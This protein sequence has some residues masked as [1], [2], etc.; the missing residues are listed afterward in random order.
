M[1]SLVL[2]LALF[3]TN[4]APSPA[5]QDP[6][7]KAA[8]AIADLAAGNFAA[9]E[10]KFNARMQSAWPAGQL[11]TRWTMIVAGVG[12]HKDCAP[13][14]RVERRPG[15]DAVTTT[16]RFE[17]AAL[18]IVV[19]IDS[20]GKITGLAFRPA[21]AATA[22]Y[23]PPSYAHP[24]AYTEEEL[25][26]G[27][28]AWLLPG[29]LT[30]PVGGGKYPAVILVHGSG[31]SDRNETL[32][33]NKPFKDIALG[34]ASRGIA[35]LRYDKRSKVHGAK[36]AASSSMTVKDEVIDDVGE[37]ITALRARPRIDAARIVVLG[38]SLGGMLISAHVAEDVIRDIADFITR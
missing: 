13:A 12:A 4:Q 31:A 9:V 34:L 29:T 3:V 32:G 38:H 26:I 1:P 35:V 23:S 24:S 25:T 2:A 30:T 33:P 14:P 17:R 7:A 10:A 20:V 11:V 36:M 19:G 15:G 28:P 21:P 18:E 16:C 22:P 6:A 37:A 27:S 5:Q 8:A